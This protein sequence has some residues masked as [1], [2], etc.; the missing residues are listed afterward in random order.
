MNYFVVSICF[1][2]WCVV[3]NNFVLNEKIIPISP[4]NRSKLKKMIDRDED[5]KINIHAPVEDTLEVLESLDSLMRV[6]EIQRKV[7]EEEF[8]G[9]KQRLLKVHKKRIQD[10]VTLAFEPLHAFLPNPL[11][12]LIIKDVHSYLKNQE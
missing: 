5:F 3:Q 7:D 12:Y 8:M 2:L 9:D 4:A 11:Q 10:I 1:F 6:E